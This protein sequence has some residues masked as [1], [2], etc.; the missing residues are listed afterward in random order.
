MNHLNVPDPHLGLAVAPPLAMIALWVYVTLLVAGGV[1]GLIKA[2]SKISL[3]TSALF[4]AL[5]ALCATGIIQPFYIADVI[6]GLLS[7]VFC[8]RYLKTSQFM[9]SGLLLLFSVVVLGVL[10]V[11][12]W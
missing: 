8:V 11:D 7:G 3:V 1:I 2:G 6:L 4:A 5:L 12:R 9:P 10:L